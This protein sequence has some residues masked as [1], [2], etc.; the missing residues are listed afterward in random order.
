MAFHVDRSEGFPLAAYSIPGREG[1]GAWPE[2]RIVPSAAAAAAASGN[3]GTSFSQKTKA[4]AR[5]DHG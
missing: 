4:P 3:P 1:R 2:S 5:N